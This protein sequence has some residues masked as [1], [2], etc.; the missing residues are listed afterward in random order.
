MLSIRSFFFLVSLLVFSAPMSPAWAKHHHPTPTPTET[1]TETETPTASPTDIPDVTKPI[2]SFDVMWGSPGTGPDQ[3]NAPEGVAVG[4]DG[5]IYIADTGNN[6][7]VVWDNSGRPVT[8]YGSFGTSATWRNPP[9]FNHP[10]AVMVLPP[11]KI[12]VSD[13]QN[14]RIVVLDENGLVLTSWGSQGTT[15]GLFNS[16]RALAQDHFGQIWVLD[17]GNNRVQGF[18]S[19]GVFVSAWGTFGTAT[20]TNNPGTM[21]LPLGMDMNFID[22]TILADTG[23]FRIQLLNSLGAP[24]TAQ[25]WFGNGPF[26]FKEPGGVV[27]LPTGKIAVTDGLTGRVEF[28][29]SKIDEYIGRWRAKDEIVNPD[30]KPHFRGIAS[31]KDGQLY[32]T[33]MQNSVILRL[34]PSQPP[35]TPIPVETPPPPT[36]TPLD[37]TPYGGAG[38][39]I[40]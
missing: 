12:F 1:E 5:N 11:R 21:N 23:N 8:T 18:S 39:P 3:L 15:T 9:Q 36:P 7:I 29:D 32:L 13:T 16:P 28:F 26:Q 35:P 6:R 40:R 27:V 25:G 2:Y 38:Y 20:G 33:D 30:Y 10:T 19:L 37:T 31:D 34:K 14:N 4:P 17:S 22:Q 24:V